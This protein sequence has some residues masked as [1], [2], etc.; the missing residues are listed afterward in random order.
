MRVP[1]S[2]IRPPGAKFVI[3]SP[4]R[5][6]A[7]GPGEKYGSAPTAANAAS[8]ASDVSTQCCMLIAGRGEDFG[9][10]L[11]ASV[12]LH[13]SPVVA[14]YPDQI[15]VVDGREPVSWPAWRIGGPVVAG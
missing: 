6:N 11:P 1:T 3:R 14:V 7:G 8:D 9:E 12:P 2:A 13:R 4:N 10:R 5:S 15:V